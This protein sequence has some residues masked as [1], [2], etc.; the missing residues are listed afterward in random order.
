MRQDIPIAWHHFRCRVPSDWEVT[1]YSMEERE[2]RLELSTRRGV[3]AVVAWLPVKG[4]PNQTVLLE[5]FFKARIKGQ[6]DPEDSDPLRLKTETVGDF[7]V[8]TAGRNL[9]YV[10]IRYFPEVQTL[11]RWV[12]PETGDPRMYEAILESCKPNHDDS[13][14]ISLFGLEFQ[15]PDGFRAES[16]SVFPANVMMAFE[17]S[18]RLRTVFRRWGMSSYILRGGTLQAFY[19]R[20]LERSGCDIKDVRSSTVNGCAAVDMDFVF[21]VPFSMEV[22]LGRSRLFGRATAWHHPDEQR[23]YAFEQ[24]GPRKVEPLEFS[25][26]FPGLHHE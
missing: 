14:E 13:K 21:K 24:M 1:F 11:L 4:D 15:L 20:M 18:K 3:Q 25:R 9:P 6:P 19:Q 10:A 22:F 16:M 17:N 7:L 26:V 2:G 5:N 23:I 8:G 12:F